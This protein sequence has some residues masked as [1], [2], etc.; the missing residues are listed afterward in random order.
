ML[1]RQISQVAVITVILISTSCTSKNKDAE[2]QDS[3]L[4]EMTSDAGPTTTS[5]GGAADEFSLDDEAPPSS[6]GVVADLGS[7][8]FSADSKAAPDSTSADSLPSE[9][10][11]E[12]DPFAETPTPQ[13]VTQV[14]PSP[15]AEPQASESV[16]SEPISE[17]PAI[18][19][20]GQESTDTTAVGAAE[21]GEK[22]T[23]S[24]KKIAEV[25]F[26]KDG[27]LLNAVYLVRAKD[28]LSGVSKKIYG[29]DKS[30]ELLKANPQFR[31]RGIKTGDK[32]YY[33]SP[34]RPE[35]ASRV[36]TY[37]EDLGVQPETYVSQEGDNIRTVAK[38][39]L[40]SKASWKELWATNSVESKDVLPVGTQLRYWRGDAPAVDTGSM[41]QQ[42]MPVEASPPPPQDTAL[43]EVAPDLQQGAPP[44]ADMPPP[45]P[46]DTMADVGAPPPPPPIQNDTPPPAAY[47]GMEPPPPPPPPT[48]MDQPRTSLEDPNQTMALAAGA[49]LLLA[50]VALFVVRRK[51]ARRQLDFNTTT[52]TQ[53]E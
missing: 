24:L 28:T 19:D 52:Q 23:A 4:A 32:V 47:G 50:A 6:D 39:L 53:I 25:P 38:S 31:G 40:G 20:P 10:L 5:E 30:S 15:L 11:G 51:K 37:H 13:D 21:P 49:V 48:Q 35:D 14:E 18:L 44:Q 27:I 46:A 29:S 3:E 17:S 1:R 43:N 9:G 26:R 42:Q 45:P 16:P 22:K 34:Q 41:A 8:D 2:A 7:E 36:L 33:N 12:D